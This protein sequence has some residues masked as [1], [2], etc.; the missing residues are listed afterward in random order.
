MTLTLTPTTTPTGRPLNHARRQR[1]RRGLIPRASSGD[2]ARANAQRACGYDP[3]EKAR[4]MVT[5]IHTLAAVRVIMAQ[6]DGFGNEC[7]EDVNQ[8]SLT[9]DLLDAMARW[10]LGVDDGRTF[11]SNLL[12]CDNH[13]LRLAAVRAIE[14]RRTYAEEDEFDWEFM[15]ESLR[16]DMETFRMGVLREHAA[17]SL[18]DER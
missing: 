17:R 8:S 14:V 9:T 13:Q 3:Q 15:R 2:E 5:R 16:E 10:P 11:L 18:D 12:A 4:E 7:S 1:Q 6:S